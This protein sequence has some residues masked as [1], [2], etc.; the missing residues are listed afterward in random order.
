MTPRKQANVNQHAEAEYSG[1]GL[2]E[3]TM[4]ERGGETKDGKRDQSVPR[5]KK[6]FSG[7][8]Q[9]SLRRERSED[10][11]GHEV[12]NKYLRGSV[13]SMLQDKVCDL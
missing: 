11:T 9:K 12:E 1:I 7:D 13:V 8:L 2:M 3:E 5:M 4:M 6:S 10:T